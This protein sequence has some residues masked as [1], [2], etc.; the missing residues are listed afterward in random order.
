M[1][2][3][4]AYLTENLPPGSIVLAAPG[5]STPRVRFLI[6]VTDTFG[7]KLEMDIY[8][9]YVADESVFPYVLTKVQKA[10]RTYSLALV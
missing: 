7:I 3:L 2:K 1:Q 8:P 4:V 5:Y 6:P 9:G 10:F